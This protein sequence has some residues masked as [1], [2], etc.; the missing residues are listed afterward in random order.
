ME[1][2]G[3]VQREGRLL[4]HHCKDMKPLTSFT[5]ALI[6][7]LI[8]YIMTDQSPMTW[9]MQR[10]YLDDLCVLLIARDV[11]RVPPPV[12]HVNVWQT[13]QQEL[14]WEG[15]GGSVGRAR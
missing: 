15:E 8:V 11:L 10:A 2:T 9:H 4:L 7:Q 3:T 12:L 5:K 13:G 14:L 1:S 6:V